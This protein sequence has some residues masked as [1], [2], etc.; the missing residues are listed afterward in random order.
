MGLFKGREQRTPCN[1]VVQLHTVEG[2]TCSLP[3]SWAP[4]NLLSPISSPTRPRLTLTPG[5]S[6]IPFR[7]A[8]P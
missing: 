2:L 5:F 6:C 1:Q 4:Q 7:T 8:P 3:S